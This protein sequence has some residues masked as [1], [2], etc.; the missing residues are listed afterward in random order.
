MN[1][2]NLGFLCGAGLLLER[3]ACAPAFSPQN[4]QMRKV[5]PL[6]QF[7]RMPL[8]P[9]KVAQTAPAPGHTDT[10][11]CRQ[12]PTRGCRTETRCPSV[13]AH[14]LLCSGA[15]TRPAG[16]AV[17]AQALRTTALGGRCSQRQAQGAAGLQGGGCWSSHQCG[18]STGGGVLA[19][20]PKHSGQQ[21]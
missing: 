16:G 13:R 17:P 1:G 20:P 19:P 11:R 5:P 8:R 12:L 7:D 15:G 18:P 4:N 9:S 14:L 6:F 3:V 2:A 10:H 21:P